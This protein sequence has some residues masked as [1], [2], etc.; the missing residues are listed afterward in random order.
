MKRLEM[1]ITGRV[2]GVFYRSY[3]R[4]NA[5]EL[6]LTGYVMNKENGTVEVIA[7]GEKEKLDELLK[8]CRKGP[9][10]AKV[11]EIKTNWK[12]AEEEFDEFNIRKF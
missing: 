1:K 7:E 2:Q 11:T 5:R 9:E 4:D 6:G 12:D 8:R 10:A 3:T